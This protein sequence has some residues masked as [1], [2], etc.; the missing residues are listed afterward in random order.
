MLSLRR[1]A[2]PDGRRRVRPRPRPVLPISY[3][4]I[5]CVSRGPQEIVEEAERASLV[6]EIEALKAELARRPKNTAANWNEMGS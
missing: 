5:N 2:V 1:D 4:T 6:A 3:R